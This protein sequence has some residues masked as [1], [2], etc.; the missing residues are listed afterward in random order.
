MPKHDLDL[1]RDHGSNYNAFGY[2]ANGRVVYLVALFYGPDW[3]PRITPKQFGGPPA[4]PHFSPPAPYQKHCLSPGFRL[5]M[6]QDYHKMAAAFAAKEEAKATGVE[7]DYLYHPDEF[8]SH[9]FN[10][11]KFGRKMVECE[12]AV[13]GI[14]T[15]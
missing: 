10:A 14:E 7:T 3:V 5:R 9:I 15:R 12:F 2:D 1:T 11:F 8:D 4:L 6:H 13:Q